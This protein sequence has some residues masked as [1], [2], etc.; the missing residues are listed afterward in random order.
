MGMIFSM[1]KLRIIKLGERGLIRLCCAGFA[2]GGDVCGFKNRIN[3]NI[4][5][6]EKNILLC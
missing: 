4:N 6:V 1:G 3:K 5:N 2:I